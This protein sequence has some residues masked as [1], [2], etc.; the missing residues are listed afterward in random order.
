M[1]IKRGKAESHTALEKWIHTLPK[2]I[3]WMV[4]TLLSTQHVEK[5]L[6]N[7]IDVNNVYNLCH[8]PISCTVG[9]SSEN[10]F[11]IWDLRKI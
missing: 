7:G 8:V 2:Q 4:F 10:Q 5:C 3:I 6:K 9:L 1:Q 11:S